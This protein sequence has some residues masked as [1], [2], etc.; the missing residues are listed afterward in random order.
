M[1]WFAYLAELTSVVVLWL[2]GRALLLA[3]L[4]WLGFHV[5]TAAILYI[6][7]A[8]TLICWLAFAPLEHLPSWFR[9]V[10]AGRRQLAGR[11]AT[12][13]AMTVR[14]DEPVRRAS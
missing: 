4:F 6:H 11:G 14:R 3:A 1:Q 13:H 9:R 5:F 10:I 7:F 2:R 12:R 8:P